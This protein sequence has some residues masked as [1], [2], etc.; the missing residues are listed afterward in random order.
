MAKHKPRRQTN[1]EKFNA[2]NAAREFMPEII[3]SLQAEVT[4]G[5]GIARI[6]AAAELIKLAELDTIPQDIDDAIDVQDA[7][8]QNEKIIP[9]SEAV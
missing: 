9:M 7:T 1:E 8:P 3:K 2:R 6:K 5:Q 4:H